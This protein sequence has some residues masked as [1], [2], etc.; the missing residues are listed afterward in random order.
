MPLKGSDCD[1]N[2]KSE[3]EQE[4]DNITVSERCSSEEPFNSSELL[5][6]RRRRPTEPIQL[7][8][9]LHS[10]SSDSMS[11]KV[12]PLHVQPSRKN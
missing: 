7:Q 4:L 9:R 2:V 1:E 10:D 5:G 6:R 11:R 3:D 12:A 8:A